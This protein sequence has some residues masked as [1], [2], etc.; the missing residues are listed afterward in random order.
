MP[1]PAPAIHETP[2]VDD[3]LSS[4]IHAAAAGRFPPA[5]GGVT[6]VAPSHPTVETVVAFTGHAVIATWL[7]SE[8]VAAQRPDGFG[9]AVRP[10]FLLWLAGEG[11]DVGSHDVLLVARGLGEPALPACDDLDGHPRGAPRAHPPA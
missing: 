1:S 7:S 2:C 11:G 6:V 10:K 8:A 5:D 3:S 9:G 4:L